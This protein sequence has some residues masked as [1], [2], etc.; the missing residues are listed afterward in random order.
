MN[1]ARAWIV[2]HGGRRRTATAAAATDSRAAAANTDGAPPLETALAAFDPPPAW[3][4]GLGVQVIGL[5][6]DDGSPAWLWCSTG[7]PGAGADIAAAIDLAAAATPL[8][9]LERL[10]DRLLAA[11]ASDPGDYAALAW[12]PAGPPHEPA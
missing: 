6:I 11:S 3:P 4:A 5:V 1:G 7:W 9:W 12:W 10:E 8:D 2:R